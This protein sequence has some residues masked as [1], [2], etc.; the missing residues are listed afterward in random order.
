MTTASDLVA[1]ERVLAEW[2]LP[3]LPRARIL[4]FIPRLDERNVI[5]HGRKVSAE[6]TMCWRRPRQFRPVCGAA[7][8]MGNV[9]HCLASQ[10]TT[11]VAGVVRV[12]PRLSRQ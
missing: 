10:F 7:A 1:I 8:R 3:E 11:R 2:G 9:P 5:A 6:Q 12:K 4:Y